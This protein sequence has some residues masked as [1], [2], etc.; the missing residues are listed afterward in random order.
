MSSSTTPAEL[1]VVGTVPARDGGWF[2]G[3]SPSV[4]EV[5]PGVFLIASIAR[6]KNQCIL[7]LVQPTSP[8]ST[9]TMTKVLAGVPVDS[10]VS[11]SS[12]RATSPVPSPVLQV[13]RRLSEPD[14]VSRKRPSATSDMVPMTLKSGF[15]V[16]RIIQLV[17]ED[18]GV[19]ETVVL[20]REPLATAFVTALEEQDRAATKNPLRGAIAGAPPAASASASPVPSVHRV[21]VHFLIG[22]SNGTVIVGNALRGTILAV[23]Q[24]QYHHL[25]DSESRG[26][27]STTT[28]TSPAAA[29]A[30]EA[31]GDSNAPAKN[32][33]VVKFVVRERREEHLWN[34]SLPFLQESNAALAS[35]DAAVPSKKAKR[36]AAAAAATASPTVGSRVASIYVVHSG[37]KVVEL[38]RA[39]LD[40]FVRVSVDRLDGRRPH[41]ILE[42][43]PDTSPSSFPVAGP[44][45]DF[46]A[47]VDRVFVLEPPSAYSAL[48]RRTATTKMASPESTH[49]VIR[50][51]DVVTEMPESGLLAPLDPQQQRPCESLV[52]GGSSPLFSFYR[53]QPP[54]PGFSASNAVRAVKNI[55]TGVARSLWFGALGT[56]NPVERPPHL[57]K[58]AMGG[59]RP[60]LQ[61]DAKCAALQVDPSQQWAAFAV[62]GGGRLY[63]ADVQTGVVS[64]V[65]KGCRAAQFTWWWVDS[66]A[67]GR[68]A[69]LLVV[70][71]PLRRA[72][73]VYASRT[74]ERL[75]ACLVPEGSVL[76]RACGVPS[77]RHGSNHGDQQRSSVCSGAG[78]GALLMDP[79]GTVY[80]VRIAWT[81]QN[82]AEGA[83]HLP[84]LL[85]H[86]A[87]A[88]D[89]AATTTPAA[90]GTSLL[91]ASVLRGCQKPDDFLEVSLQ[92]PLPQPHVTWE[93]GT[94][95]AAVAADD[96]SD[97][98]VSS[99]TTA[100]VVTPRKAYVVKGGDEVRQY[101]K[102]L[103]LL[104]STVQRRFAPGYAEIVTAPMP[105]TP[106]QVLEGSPAGVPHNT[107]AAQCLHYMRQFRSLTENYYRLLSC[108]RVAPS[109]YF[110]AKQWTSGL[111]TSELWKVNFSTATAANCAATVTFVRQMEERMTALLACFPAEQSIFKKSFLGHF[112]QLLRKVLPV[113]DAQAGS[114]C[115]LA[116]PGS[117][118]SLPVFLRCF[119]C[120]TAR[121]TFLSRA[122][123]VAEDADGSVN[124]IGP[125]SD[126]AFGRL[127]LDSF[128]AQLPAL[129]E[130]GC[131]DGDVALITVTW[132]ARQG[133]RGLHALLNSTTVGLFSAI[134]L[135][136]SDEHF[137][138]ALDRA[139]IPFISV[140]GDLATK[141]ATDSITG[142]LWCCAVRGTLRPGATL[143]TGQRL[144]RR[145]RQL[146]Q[147]WNSLTKGSGTRPSLSGSIVAA[148]D[149]GGGGNS[150]A[151]LQEQRSTPST[152]GRIAFSLR[153]GSVE[154][155]SLPLTMAPTGLAAG[156][157]AV[158]PTDSVRKIAK[159]ELLYYGNSQGSSSGCCSA[160]AAARASNDGDAFEVYLQRNGITISLLE[161]FT[162]PRGD[163]DPDAVGNLPLF[164]S[165]VSSLGSTEHVRSRSSGACDSPDVVES[166][167]WIEAHQWDQDRFRNEVTKPLERLWQQLIAAPAGK[168]T[169]CTFKSTLRG[170]GGA[171]MDKESRSSVYTSCLL[172]VAMSVLEHA[173]RPLTDVT[174]FFWDNNA[175]P[176]GNFFPVDGAPEG[177]VLSGSRTSRE[178]L[179]SVQKLAAL[180]EGM[181][182]H[183]VTPLENA[184][185]VLLIQN[186]SMAL[187]EDDALLF[188]LVPNFLRTRLTVWM[189][190]LA[191]APHAPLRR[192]QRVGRLVSLLLF[193]SE[194]SA[195]TMG[196]GV[197]LTQL[198]SQMSV[199]WKDLIGGANR[200]EQLRLLPDVFIADVKSAAPS[201]SHAQESGLALSTYA[202]EDESPHA[203]PLNV[204]VAAAVLRRFLVAGSILYSQQQGQLLPSSS[205]SAVTGAGPLKPCLNMV[206]DDTRQ[207]IARLAHCLGLDEARPDIAN[208]VLMDYEIKHLFPVAS[209]EQEMLLLSTKT[210][211]P[212]V[213]LSVLQC[214]LVQLLQ[215]VSTQRKGYTQRGDKSAVEVA[216][217]QLRR[218]VEVLS[219]DSRAWL[220]QRETAMMAASEASKAA[221]ERGNSAS[222]PRGTPVIAEADSAANAAV[223]PALLLCDASWV[224]VTEYR[225]MRRLVFSVLSLPKGTPERRNLY[226]VLFTLSQWACEGRLTLPIPLQRIAREL[227]LIVESWEKVV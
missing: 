77:E 157:A 23:A 184:D 4:V 135:T 188:P 132:I 51:A 129:T 182:Q 45:S 58:V 145:I 100:A 33:A 128:F 56:T 165:F 143:A 221:A 159:K 207:C 153:L 96:Q 48:E 113:T 68:P 59:G 84:L 2:S 122:I 118:M 169:N 61:A 66:S 43:E 46:A 201:P 224:T 187:S 163:A 195:L 139:P 12:P 210:A 32:Q 140:E 167:P 212:H 17:A 151:Q 156:P 15:R 110:D 21:H 213:G 121:P 65:L 69:L 92:L 83:A 131:S 171:P 150:G 108:R 125:F 72:V 149:G 144:T 87:D 147:L 137:L 126:L 53:L 142:L 1:A 94:A 98:G 208:I 178:Y 104:C 27:R 168:G 123:A 35:E 5:F 71:L 115:T 90:E 200:R 176:D 196:G 8:I 107:T 19:I 57:K 227:P 220:Q 173:I 31:A 222:S 205:L 102:S 127:G 86:S 24:F 22:T 11:G 225:D 217:E 85:P 78:S 136:F 198:Q 214:F 186:I 103:E 25:F 166:L 219:P 20:V 226:Q 13:Q 117:F 30:G 41:L 193:F 93:D 88:V 99:A 148:R 39:A 175:I 29:E 26:S 191:Q 70:Y 49:F 138:R 114:T 216:S 162:V 74:W 183:S 10:A 40:V 194:A 218:L 161:N 189:Q 3:V 199:P 179:R 124:F 34:P 109:R 206:T 160:G 177:I 202:M 181:V 64:C 95:P 7:E 79:A 106:Q 44:A 185:R 146:L 28:S 158:D 197:A 209:I 6:A 170:T 172:L 111:I 62:E 112:W 223:D 9:P 133:G 55:V 60:L 134:L 47:Y 67:A 38:T 119:Y 101:C 174:F 89:A 50:D 130:L 116:D 54:A 82:L 192:V 120:G 152:D 75:A 180:V 76:L 203:A 16:P 190:V 80:E 14:G 211:A 155:P 52:V 18:E 36:T 215:Y 73:E 91:S 97:T 141:T 164:S 42:W 37:G 154:P 204:G 63:V 105:C 81:L